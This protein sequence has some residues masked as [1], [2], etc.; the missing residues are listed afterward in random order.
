M[1]QIPSDPELKAIE[2]ALAGLAP[3]SSRL[4]RDKLMFA[5]GAM[6]RPG[7]RERR[8]AWPAITATLTVALAGES[9]FLAA[10]PAPRVVERIVLVPAP[11]AAPAAPVS[12][13]PAVVSE[14]SEYSSRESVAAREPVTSGSWAV[15]SDYERLEEMVTRFGL[16]AVPEPDPITPRALGGDE[17]TGAGPSS[18]GALRNLELQKILNPGDPS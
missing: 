4:N 13:A 17:P 9:L 18:A 11:T 14:R 6:S 12:A 2:A 15:A 5:A 7:A 8:W 16:D 3:L 10:R 1:P